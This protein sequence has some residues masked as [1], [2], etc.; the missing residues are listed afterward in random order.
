MP[1]LKK[2]MAE[3]KQERI[4]D[5]LKSVGEEQG[6]GAYEFEVI[7]ESVFIDGSA[8]VMRD[9]DV[10]RVVEAFFQSPRAVNVTV[11]LPPNLPFNHERDMIERVVAAG[12]AVAVTGSFAQIVKQRRQFIMASA[13]SAI[14]DSTIPTPLAGELKDEALSPYY[15]SMEE[16]RALRQAYEEDDENSSIAS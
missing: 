2:L 9:V 7:E 13:K 11:V 4:T 5:R 3:A 8:F 14:S 16:R 1:Q 6:L 10:S 12:G 15:Y